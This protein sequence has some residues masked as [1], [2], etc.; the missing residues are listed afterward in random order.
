MI[1]VDLVKNRETKEPNPELT[2]QIHEFSKDVG[3]LLGKGS[4]YRNVVRIEPPLCIT[5]AD[6]D[7]VIQVLDFALASYE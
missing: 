5:A 7:F 2:A 1:G 4:F 6:V 3:L